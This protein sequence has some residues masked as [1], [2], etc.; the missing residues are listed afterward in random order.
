LAVSD[1]PGATWAFAASD[2]VPSQGASVLAFEEGVMPSL[3]GTG[4]ALARLA[5]GIVLAVSVAS[6]SVSA[7]AMSAERA[8]ADPCTS[9]PAVP[10]S[11][12]ALFRCFYMASVRATRAAN[13]QVS[14]ETG[15]NASPLTAE[16]LAYAATVT[17]EVLVDMVEQ[18]DGKS[19]VTQIADVR[20]GL[21]SEPSVN[22]TGGVMT[23]TV[24]PVLGTLGCP[25][26]GQIEQAAMA[27]HLA[28]VSATAR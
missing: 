28:P 10:L 5:A 23:I 1:G 12:S 8:T 18:P 27:Q 2:D 21:G 14:F 9:W 26:A 22:L 11:P 24:V 20:V 17:S 25:S 6:A 15:T 4:L 3:P 19:A 16:S 13:H 7:P